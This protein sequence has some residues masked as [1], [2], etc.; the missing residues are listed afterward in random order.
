MIKMEYINLGKT[1]LKISRLGI[2]TWA[3]GGFGWGKVNDNDS[4]AA[5]RRAWEAGLN[6]F[7]TAD[8]YGQGHAEE[9]LAKA[10]GK[11][12]HCAVIAT[13]FGVRLRPDGKTFKDISP[14]Y[15]VQALEASLRRLK[16]DCIP[17]Y[18]IHWPDGVTPVEEIMAALEDCRRQGKIL[19]IGYSNFAPDMVEK[20][21]A[22]GR[23][24]SLQMPYSLIDRGAEKELMPVCEKFALTPL[25]YGTLAQGLLSG[26][27]A[28]NIKLD[29]N[30]ARRRC[31]GW[32]AGE[33]ENSLK[34]ANLVAAIGKK[35]QKTGA[36]TAIRWALDKNYRGAVL[37]GVTRPDQVD[38][39]LGAL[40]WHLPQ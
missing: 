21:Q 22:A 14:K 10:L 28:A 1:N 6:F 20:A 5:L 30:D 15:M 7:D 36:Q 8:V 12:R 3:I 31:V 32:R 34:Q 16:I 11:N 27:I 9:I 2:G 33:F 35:Y 18:Q 26:K 19:H 38:E 13:K 25:T 29:A 4:I 40:D 37:V 23:G 17:L 24:E 39:N